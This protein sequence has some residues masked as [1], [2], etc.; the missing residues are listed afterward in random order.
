MSPAQ[1]AKDPLSALSGSTAQRAV[2]SPI[3]CPRGHSGLP[4]RI[5]VPLI[6]RKPVLAGLGS[7]IQMPRMLRRQRKYVVKAARKNESRTR[8][9]LP[10]AHQVSFGPNR[11]RGIAGHH[12]PVGN[13]PRHN[14]TRTD[15]GLG[16][17]SHTGQYQRV[18]SN[19][20]AT[21]NVHWRDPRKPDFAPNARVM[22]QNASSR[23]N[24]DIILDGDVASVGPV[25][26][27]SRPNED[28]PPYADS[29]GATPGGSVSVAPHCA[30]A[31]AAATN[32]ERP[33]SLVRRPSSSGPS[34]LDL[35]CG[36]PPLA[37]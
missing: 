3:C 9:F 10:A 23:H 30:G 37:I 27:N 31:T 35:P 26:L 16:A 36:R 29:P 20:C 1:A 5:E 11:P 19:E 12:N 7:L 33:P 15:H 32:D 2:E 13:I 21:T 14:R 8:R 22:T 34:S 6:P 4:A 25:Q 17:D 28:I 18:C 24:R